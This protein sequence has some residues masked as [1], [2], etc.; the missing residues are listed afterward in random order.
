MSS[1]NTEER[2]RKLWQ[3][4]QRQEHAKMRLCDDL[5]REAVTYNNKALHYRQERDFFQSVRN[6]VRRQEAQLSLVCTLGNKTHSSLSVFITPNRQFANELLQEQWSAHA[7]GKH[8]DLEK[9]IKKLVVITA[10]R[11]KLQEQLGMPATEDGYVDC[12]KHAGIG[13]RHYMDENMGG[14]SLFADEEWRS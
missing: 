4:K 14:S 1:T 12:G 9:Q 11:K 5:Q 10:A 3:D 8:Y 6:G 13:V 7:V 2:T